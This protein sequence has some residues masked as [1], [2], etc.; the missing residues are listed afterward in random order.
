MIVLLVGILL[1]TLLLAALSFVQLGRK[2]TG[3]L[4]ALGMF[5]FGLLW[6]VFAVDSSSSTQQ[7]AI[8]MF[9]LVVGFVTMIVVFIPPRYWK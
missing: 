5:L 9:P 8:G 4:I 7:L 6:I 1:F 2:M 3:F